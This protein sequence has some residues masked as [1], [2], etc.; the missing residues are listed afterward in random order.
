MIDFTEGIQEYAIKHSDRE[1]SIL[2][3]LTEATRDA[4][5]GPA[6]ISGHIVGTFLRMLVQITESKRILEIGTFSGYSSLAMAMG[7]PDDG[8][9]ITLD[10]NEEMATIARKYWDRT[11]LGKLIELKLGPVIENLKDIDGPFDMAFIGGTKNDYVDFWDV[12]VDKLK[13]GGVIV[14]DNVLLS[15][16]VL[17]PKDD[18]AETIDAF[19]EHVRYDQRVQRLMLTVHDGLTLARKF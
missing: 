9:I 7:L 15:G 18:M 6:K 16:T 3:D 1:A 13:S 8:K 10:N 11:H 17:N 19:N 4:V 2:Y 5:K 14:V 12:A